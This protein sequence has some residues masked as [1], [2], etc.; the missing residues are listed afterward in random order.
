M[1]ESKSEL[2]DATEWGHDS[3]MISPTEIIE[4]LKR[5]TE[6]AL[7]EFQALPDG[8]E[9]C[10]DSQGCCR[11]SV[12]VPVDEILFDQLMNGCTGYRA[13]YS[14]GIV[15]GEEFNRRLVDAIAPI[16]V[17]AESLYRDKFERDLCQRSLLGRFSKFWF[18]K[19]ITDPSVQ[20]SLLELKEELRVPRW[21]A[22][23]RNRPKPW[24]G[25]LV[26]VPE[27][28]AVLLNGTFVNA[29]GEEYEQKPERSTQVFDSGWT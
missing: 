24:K 7:R 17:E 2:P 8:P 14:I 27:S 12:C 22:Y 19:E 3:P 6:K 5:K 1:E 11:V 15:I 10:N 21:T 18:P 9:D 28:K 4:E 13:H 25:L 29:A 16:I 23:W 26:P 20:S